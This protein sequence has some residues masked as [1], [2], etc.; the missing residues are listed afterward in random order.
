[1]PEQLK[2]HVEAWRRR[3]AEQAAF[4]ASEVQDR[5]FDLYGPLEGS[6]TLDQIQ[7]WLL[8]TRQRQLFSTEE[9]SVFL[10]EIELSVEVEAM[11]EPSPA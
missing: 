5:L 9:L 8:L 3:L 10:D 2:F 11:Q 6:Q 7:T 4:S 1:M